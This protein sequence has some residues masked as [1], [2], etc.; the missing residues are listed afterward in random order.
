[1]SSPKHEFEVGEVDLA[2]LVERTQGPRPWRRLFHA[3]IGVLIVLSLRFLV[4]SDTV[5]LILLGSTLVLL[6]LLEWVRLT[7]PRMNLLFFKFLLPLVSPREEHKIISSVWYALGVLIAVAVFPR[8][9]AL[10][11]ILVTALADPAA[12]YVGRRWGRT[13]LGKG[14]VMGTV[15]FGVTGLLVLVPFVGIGSAAVAATVASVIEILPWKLD[16]NLTVPLS[17]GFALW[18]MTFA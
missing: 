14:T 16:D 7:K 8:E 17:S 6:L 11:S 18:I 13:R 12:G 1:M 2:A 5:A 9:I 10:L 4:P 15:T 3:A